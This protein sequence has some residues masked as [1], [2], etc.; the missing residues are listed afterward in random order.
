MKV[1]TK[2]VVVSTNQEKEAGRGLKTDLEEKS[3]YFLLENAIT[4][5]KTYHT[6]FNTYICRSRRDDDDG[7]EKRRSRSR[8]GNRSHHS[9]FSRHERSDKYVIKLA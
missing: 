4:L 8:S 3:W 7:R 1:D 6:I 2:I 5:C 9:R